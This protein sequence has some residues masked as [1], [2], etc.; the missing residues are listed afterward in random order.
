MKGLLVRVGIDSTDGRWIA[1]VRTATD[2]F[3][4]ISIT[5]DKPP[6]EDMGRYYDEF[7][8]VAA[9]FN[10]PLP[11]H[12]KG[13]PTHLDPD[14]E[15]LTYGDRGRR[16]KRIS[17]LSSGDLLAFY[18]AL[19]PVDGPK[20]P[21]VYALIGLYIIDEI[22]PA[23]SIQKNRWQENAHTRR[24]PQPDDVVVHAQRGASGRLCHCLPIGELRD[25][26]YRVRR[27][28][29]EV[30]GGL[31]VRDGYIH[32]SGHLPAF[33]DAE[34]FYHWFLNRHPNL[35]AANNPQS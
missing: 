6:R 35:I 32:R 15:W 34:K 14:F 29:L 18:A 12:L 28:L 21:L 5:E 8:S 7:R 19:Q 17:S 30:W 31:D 10:Q 24:A 25:R 9:R 1:P 11:D 4:Y 16:G 23:C 2:E 13:Q 33:L 22:V 27:D 20:R 3:A 26:F